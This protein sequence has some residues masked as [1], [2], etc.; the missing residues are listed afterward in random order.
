MFQNNTF[1]L[2][3]FVKYT[4]MAAIFFVVLFPGD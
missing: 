4:N 2:E 3:L 1:L